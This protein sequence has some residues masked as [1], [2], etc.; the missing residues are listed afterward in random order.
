MNESAS[1][2]IEQEEID[3]IEPRMDSDPRKQLYEYIIDPEPLDDSRFDEGGE[4]D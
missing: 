1:T 4:G 2:V 3:W